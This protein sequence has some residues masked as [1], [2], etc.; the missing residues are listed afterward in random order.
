MECLARADGDVDAL[1]AVLGRDLSS[2]YRYLLIAEELLAA[3]RADEATEWAERGLAAFDE[4]ADPRLVDFVCERYAHSG[5]HDQATQLAWETL[6]QSR[7]VDA[8]QRLAK[9]TSHAGTWESWRE[10][11]RDAAGTRGR[12]GPRRARRE[13]RRL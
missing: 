9:V 8:Y 7:R 1:V 3:G 4:R 12:R 5:R 13:R 11:A 10:P 2:P 6:E